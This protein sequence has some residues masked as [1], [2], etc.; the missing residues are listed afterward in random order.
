MEDL[1]ITAA[2]LASSNMDGGTRVVF[3]SVEPV[4]LGEYFTVEYEG[5]RLKFKT[6]IVSSF[7]G[8]DLYAITANF[9]GNRYIEDS[10]DVKKLVGLELTKADEE[11]QKRFKDSE[12]LC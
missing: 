11:A 6:C 3:G 12:G 4:K 10:L 7:P 5:E 2:Q 8:T 1:K 9:R